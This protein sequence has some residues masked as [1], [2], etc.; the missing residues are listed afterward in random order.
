MTEIMANRVDAALCI[1]R[2]ARL[3]LPDVP[4]HRT[5]RGNGRQQTS[6]SDDDYSAYR[7]AS[8]STI[9]TCSVL[10]SRRC[11]HK[12]QQDLRL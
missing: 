8:P 6:F 9:A 7:S 2:L 3:I 4:R 10:P 11:S 5:Q 12:R 1:A